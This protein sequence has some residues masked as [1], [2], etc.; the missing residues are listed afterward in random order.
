M[1]GILGVNRKELVLSLGQ[2]K[3][4]KNKKKLK[5]RNEEVCC[6]VIEKPDKKSFH[7]IG[8]CYFVEAAFQKKSVQKNR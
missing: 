8:T 5:K 3:K 4:T 2:S 6:K 7:E 1:S